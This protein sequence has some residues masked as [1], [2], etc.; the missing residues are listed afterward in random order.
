MR[1]LPRGF[2]PYGWATSTEE[3]ARRTGLNPIEI[4]RFDGNTPAQPPRSA[5]PATVAAGADVTR[6]RILSAAAS[7]RRAR[8]G[9]PRRLWPSNAS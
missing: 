6:T 1:P 4:V 9:T 5:R 7:R 8:R 2:R 3:L